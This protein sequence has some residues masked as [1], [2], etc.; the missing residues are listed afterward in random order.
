M[1]RGDRTGPYGE[2][3]RTGRGLGYCTGHQN[4][5]YTKPRRALGRPRRGLRRGLG[6]RIRRGIAPPRR[7]LRR[8]P[9]TTVNEPTPRNEEEEKE[10]LNEEKEIVKEE[11]EEL[12]EELENIDTRIKEITE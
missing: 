11:I 10:L 5:G 8:I 2:G 12:K 1:P 7:G 9:E 4:P 3:S 6:R